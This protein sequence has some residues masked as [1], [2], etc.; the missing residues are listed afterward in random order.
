MNP[1]SI[2]LTRGGL[3]RR[4]GVSG[5]A[6]RFYETRKLLP[7]PERN[8]SG[9]RQYSSESVKRVQFIK[10]AQML[11]FTLEEIAELLQL[12]ADPGGS[13][14]EVKAVAIEKL[15]VIDAKIRDLKRMKK[16]LEVLVNACDGQGP[17]HDCPILTA[18]EED[19]R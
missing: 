14:R 4:V 15:V 1:K 17:R 6:I 13:S 16:S 18:I 19:A 2:K 8:A 5:E 9:Y 11:G 7:E 3:A 10:R 12:R